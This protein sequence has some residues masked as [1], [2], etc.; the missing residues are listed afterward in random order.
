MYDRVR[1]LIAAVI[2]IF[3]AGI[4]EANI[5]ENSRLSEKSIFGGILT[6]SKISI[7]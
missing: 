5:G 3:F 7:W 1:L 4:S 2:I 6:R